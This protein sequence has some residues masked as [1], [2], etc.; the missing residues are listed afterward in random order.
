[1]N[2]ERKSKLTIII[3]ALIWGTIGVFRKFIDMPSGSLAMCRGFVAAGFLWCYM[4]RKGIKIDARKNAKTLLLL[5]LTGG[6]IGFNWIVLFEAY[7]Y[8][9]VSVATLCYYMQPIF[10]IIASG[11][12]FKEKL[13]AKK[14]LCV[15]AAF[16]GMILVSGVLTEGFSDGDNIHGVMLGLLAG[17]MYAGVVIFNKY[18][19]GIDPYS[20]T[21]VQLL[22]A[23]IVVLPYVILTGEWAATTF[24][25]KT[26]ALVLFLGIVHTGIAYAMYFGAVEKVDMQ[27]VALFG[28]IDPVT[29]CILSTVVLGEK[30]S[31]TS[32]IGAVLI[33]GAAVV[34]ELK[35]KRSGKLKRS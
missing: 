18:I 26:T 28:Y 17:V 9:S 10:L 20:K 4:R 21:F 32:I 25:A 7:N 16:V 13:N 8:T 19:T 2:E 35:D 1:M 23:A 27:T 22:S 31:V 24:D 15:I 14:V 3:C 11:I 33:I 30:M 5:V 34:S 6:L 29:A 12:L